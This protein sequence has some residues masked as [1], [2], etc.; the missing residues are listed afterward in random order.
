M[1]LLEY[2]LKRPPPAA[3]ARERLDAHVRETVAWHFD[4][5]TGCDFWL[6]TAAG[7]DFDP[8]KEIG[9]YEDLRRANGIRRF[10]EERRTLKPLFENDKASYFALPNELGLVEFQ[11]SKQNNICHEPEGQTLYHVYRDEEEPDPQRRYKAQG[12][13]E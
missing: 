4:P 3:Q 8:S 10:S 12:D 1:E 5:K 6:E 9:G 7:W 11:G 13:L 2:S